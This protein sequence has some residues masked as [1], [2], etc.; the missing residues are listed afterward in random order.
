MCKLRTENGQ[1]MVEFGLILPLLILILAGM[2]DLGGGIRDYIVTTN[3]VQVGARYGSFNPSDSAGIQARIQNSA[4]GTSMTITSVTVSYPNGNA[5]GN[6]I[7]VQVT[8]QVSTILG[9]I[10]G[11]SGITLHSAVQDVIF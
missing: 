9:S 7:M 4:S 6:P 5:S 1:S 2:V 8:Y 11:I 10:L 3:A